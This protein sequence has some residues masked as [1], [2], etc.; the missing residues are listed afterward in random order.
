VLFYSSLQTYI[1]YSGLK[2]NLKLTPLYCRLAIT[3]PIDLII[4]RFSI[5][6]LYHKSRC[7]LHRKY[8]MKSVHDQTFVYSKTAGLDA[9]MQ[10]LHFQSAIHDAAQP[11]GMIS[12]EKWFISMMSI[13]DFLLAATIVYLRLVQ[14]MEQ[15]VSSTVKEH[16][17]L[18]NALERSHTVWRE[19]RENTSEGKKASD[20][21]ELMVRNIRLKAGS[22]VAPVGN[23]AAL[24]TGLSLDGVYSF[25]TISPYVVRFWWEDETY[26]KDAPH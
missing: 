10:L 9:S 2:D 11:G 15:N 22:V 5:A 20:V 14:A 12:G 19:T 7:V 4:Q 21:L 17:D 24:L 6:V 26:T 25:S 3:D 13:H 18:I 23:G 1:P 16:Q 8:L